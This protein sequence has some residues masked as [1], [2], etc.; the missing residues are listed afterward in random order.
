MDVQ[1]NPILLCCEKT[2]SYCCPR[3]PSDDDTKTYTNGQSS[4][5][6]KVTAPKQMEIGSGNIEL[7]KTIPF[8]VPRAIAGDANEPSNEDINEW[9][10]ANTVDFYNE[11][12]QLYGICEQDTKRFVEP[13]EGFP[14]AFEYRWA[15]ASGEI[16]RVS[17]P[18]YV[19]LAITW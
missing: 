11:L 15:D 3:Y 17:S 1:K 8:Q 14:K 19:D 4:P 6:E 16:F 10:A 13:G 2:Y 12:T 5:E 18:N 9:I 7:D